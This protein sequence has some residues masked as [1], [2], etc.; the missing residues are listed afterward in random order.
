[1]LKPDET[2]MSNTTHSFT[3]QSAKIS[4]ELLSNFPALPPRKLERLGGLDRA[5][6]EPSHCDHG[7]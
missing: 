2:V 4:V 5:V 6:K 7:R 3:R 1:M